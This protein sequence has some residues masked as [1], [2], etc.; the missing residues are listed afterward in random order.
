VTITLDLAGVDRR[1]GLTIEPEP[2]APLVLD[3][4]MPVK[5]DRRR[6]TETLVDDVSQSVLANLPVSM[7]FSVT[8]AAGQCG[9]KRRPMRCPARPAVL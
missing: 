7:V 2:V 8:D 4:P 6:S 5:G 9:R 3:L 1:H